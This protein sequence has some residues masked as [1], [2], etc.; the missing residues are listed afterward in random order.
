M[1]YNDALIEKEFL[2]K[3]IE[4]WEY[5]EEWGIADA[6]EYSGLIERLDNVNEKISDIEIEGQWRKV[7]AEFVR[8]DKEAVGRDGDFIRWTVSV[9]NFPD[10]VSIGDSIT[11]PVSISYQYG[12]P[13]NPV[14]LEGLG[15][16]KDI[17]LIVTGFGK[18]FEK[19]WGFMLDTCDR[20]EGH[21]PKSG[22]LLEIFTLT[23]D[24]DAAEHSEHKI[25]IRVD[26]NIWC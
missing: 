19:K 11:I 3:A 12:V 26:A 14:F 8:D 18:H 21:L 22:T 13:V 2:E 24:Q 17:V 9:P 7:S 20:K 25:E 23:V 16:N 4:T 6:L 10:S 1:E 15:R 5:L